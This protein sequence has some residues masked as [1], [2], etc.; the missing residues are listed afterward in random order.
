M[1][2]QG[3]E[4]LYRILLPKLD[5]EYIRKCVLSAQKWYYILI[6]NTNYLYNKNY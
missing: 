4:D 5:V 2:R 3:N 1:H 6:K